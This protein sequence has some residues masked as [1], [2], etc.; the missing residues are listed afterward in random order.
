MPC[1]HCVAER[2]RGYMVEYLRRPGM[3]EILRERN[4]Q[5]VKKNPA[6][7]K[8]AQK[9]FYAAHPGYAAVKAA[10]RY[11]E[12]PRVRERIR[13]WMK[14]HPEVRAVVKSNRRARITAAGGH[15]TAREW[16]EILVRHGNRCAYCGKSAAELG[17]RLEMD[18]VV[19]IAKGGTNDASNVVP[20]CR[21]C[22][23]RKGAKVVERAARWARA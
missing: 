11:R 10:R 17:R 7:Y 23:A 19:P 2:M 20:A 14:A 9:R 5:K 21:S 15:V 4:R 3:K 6:V 13:K 22:N 18:H 1:K 12:D 8:A 16:R